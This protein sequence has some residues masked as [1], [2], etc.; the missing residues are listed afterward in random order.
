MRAKANSHTDYKPKLIGGLLDDSVFAIETNYTLPDE[1]VS[2]IRI[3]LLTPEELAKCQKKESPPKPKV[4]AK[5]AKWAKRLL[6]K[7]ESDY[8][9]TIQV[10]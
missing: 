7:R 6:Q 9:T 1:L 10:C 5:V 2:A 3:F 4:D 8:E